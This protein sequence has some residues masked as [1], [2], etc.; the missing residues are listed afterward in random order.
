MD[1]LTWM[2]T[3]MLRGAARL[4]PSARREWAEAVRAEAD[5]VPAGWPRVGWLAGGLWLAV[6][7]AEIMRKVVYWLGIG[8]VAA[9]AAWAVWLSW[10]TSPAADALTVTDRVRVLVGV[11]ALAL[12]PWVGRRHGWFGP[13]GSSI[14][15]RLVRVAGCVAACGLGAAIVRMDSQIHG[16]PHGPGPF[17]LSRE[18]AA[19]VILAAGLAALRV[20]RARWPQVD[21]YALW[22][23]AGM[24][25]VI[26][27][28]LLPA[29]GIA[30][31]YVAA[32]LAATSR[33]SLVASGSLAAGAMTGLPAGLAQAL[34]IYG[35]NTPDDRYVGLLIVIMMAITFLFA[36]PAGVA[37]AWLR[38]GNEDPAELREARI[39]QGLLAG[40]VSGAAAGLVLTDFVP[41]AVFMMVL[42]PLL[43]A[44]GGALGGAV[45]AYHPRKPRPARSWAAGLFVRSGS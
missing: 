5:L 24:T 14:A 8:A 37:A 30:A 16:G 29:Q 13:V 2:L 27:L 41:I 36:V 17:S 28:V 34:A 18:I 21:A 26:V 43:G 9:A 3:K 40:S 10:H 4:L 45:A 20:V 23:S 31:L 6:K 22:L 35:L 1:R 12:L 32:I 15:A 44:A 33:R 39:R 11:A 42:G 25:G 38:S 7:E 19:A